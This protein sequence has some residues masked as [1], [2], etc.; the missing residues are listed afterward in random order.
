[1]LFLTRYWQ[2][3]LMS[4]IYLL[5]IFT[6]IL[7]YLGFDFGYIKYEI[8]IF[9]GTAISILLSLVYKNQFYTT[10][11][12]NF[13]SR[14][15]RKKIP[16]YFFDINFLVTAAVIF[17]CGVDGI[18]TKVFLLCLCIVL[19]FASMVY[20][21]SVRTISK[22]GIT[23]FAGCYMVPALLGI[24]LFSSYD[25][26][27]MSGID[28]AAYL[29]YK[30]VQNIIEKTDDELEQVEQLNEISKVPMAKI[31]VLK[32]GK[33]LLFYDLPEDLS[34][35]YEL[36]TLETYIFRDK[37]D[38]DYSIF[39]QHYYK[40]KAWKRIQAD[41]LELLKLQSESNW[42]EAA[43]DYYETIGAQQFLSKEDYKSRR[44][45]F[46]LSMVGPGIWLFWTI[47]TIGLFVLSMGLKREQEF[48]DYKIFFNDVSKRIGREIS[49]EFN[50]LQIVGS[51]WSKLA[52][53]ANIAMLEGYQVKRHDIFNN[54]DKLKAWTETDFLKSLNSYGDDK[55]VLQY[56]N[57]V[58]A[59]NAKYYDNEE[60]SNNF[61][62]DTYDFILTPWLFHMRNNLK[63]LD[64][65][66]VLIPRDVYVE[67]ILE[68][69]NSEKTLK[70]VEC[71]VFIS[72]KIE[73]QRQCRVI[74]DKLQS[75]VYNLLENSSQAGD[76]LED[77]L[78]ELNN[79]DAGTFKKEISLNISQVDIK[80]QDYLSIE[81]KDN[82]GGFPEQYLDRIYVEKIPS[83][84]LS[85]LSHSFHGNGTYLIGRFAERMGIEIIAKNIVTSKQEKGASTVLL[86]PLKGR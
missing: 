17:L 50:E 5:L 60:S 7:R 37:T 46:L 29:Y 68:T 38:N 36:S 44:F 80:K 63:E 78:Y 65:I 48:E 45:T 21:G 73:K 40:M 54:F 42:N 58:A 41:I 11:Q 3:I 55:K 72:P 35:K 33:E 74:L 59:F 1:M 16:W 57:N 30:T 51:D 76:R 20:G 24:F 66:F 79:P 83:S 18:V 62:T 85:D 56:F 13:F 70:K 25:S 23:L 19:S 69:I 10:F 26:G 75:M 61:I 84:K 2:I 49:S 53:E 86:I 31:K 34:D 82:C 27:F 15:A 81:V 71:N 22:L 28:R 4:V 43:R 14:Y 67:K 9:I 52:N 12:K 47:Q 77:R 64:D 32:N 8:I 39:Y 6:P